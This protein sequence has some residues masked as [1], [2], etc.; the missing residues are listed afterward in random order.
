MASYKQSSH[1]RH[2]RKTNEKI[3]R[4][5][6]ANIYR[7]QEDVAQTFVLTLF[8]RYILIVERQ[9]ICLMLLFFCGCECV[10]S[11]MS[12][13]FF[14]CYLKSQ[15]LLSNFD[16]NFCSGVTY[17]TR[18]DYLLQAPGLGGVGEDSRSVPAWFRLNFLYS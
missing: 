1:S 13:L 11:M 14:F 18:F 10:R 5:A 9:C 4:T 17:F 7:I 12:S 8:I 15:L 16:S 6:L 2:P 3:R